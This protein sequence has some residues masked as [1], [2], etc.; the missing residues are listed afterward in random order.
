[1]ARSLRLVS[2]DEQPELWFSIDDDEMWPSLKRRDRVR[3]EHALHP[4]AKGAVILARL[5]NRTV[6]R[7]VVSDS[8]ETIE[9]T[10]DASGGSIRL[11][12]ADVMGTI[13]LVQ[14]NGRTLSRQQWDQGPPDVDSW[15]VKVQ[16]RVVVL[17]RILAAS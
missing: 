4:V 1:M 12:I 11:P 9:V 13:S 14:R 3:L 15:R 10:A 16:K 17:F 7:R 2:P 8:N 5:F 6:A